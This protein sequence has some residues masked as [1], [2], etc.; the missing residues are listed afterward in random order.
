MESAKT[1]SMWMNVNKAFISAS[2]TVNN[3]APAF[4]TMTQSMKVWESEAI[5]G[6]NNVKMLSY[7]SQS[8]AIA[9]HEE[10]Q[11][12]TKPDGKENTIW[13]KLVPKASQGVQSALA[14]SDAMAQTANQI[15]F[16]NSGL[17]ETDN[18]QQKI[19]RSAQASRLSYQDTANAVANLGIQAKG[20]FSSS[21]EVVGFAELIGKQFQI[22]GASS[23]DTV[24]AMDQLSQTMSDGV[25]SG[26]ELNSIFGQ[27]P[28]IMQN[29]ADYMGKPIDKVM[30]MGENGQISADTLKNALFNA[31]DEIN[32]NFNSVPMTWE[33]IGTRIKNQALMA[34]QPILTKVNEIANSEKFQGFVNGIINSLFALANV[35]SPVFDSLSN[36]GSLIYDNWDIISPIIYAVAAALAFYTAIVAAHNIVEEISNTLK[37][38]AAVRSVAHGAAITS[39]MMATTGMTASQLSLNAALYACPLTWII[40]AIIALIAIIYAVVG[41]INHLTGSTLSATGVIMGALATVGAFIWNT[42]VGVINAVIQFM[43]TYFVEPFISIIEW[44]LNAFNG[45]FNSFGEAV[46]NLLGQIISW[47]LSLGK[48]VTKIIDAIFGTNWTDG[49]SSLQESVLSWGKNDEAITINRDAPAIDRINYSDAYNTGYNFGEGIDNKVSKFFDGNNPASNP[50]NDSFKDTFQGMNDSINNIDTNTASG[51]ESAGQ[52]ADSVEITD[53]DI[54]YLR[55]IAEREI[56]DRTVFKSLRVD[57]GGVNNT[58]NNMSDLNGIADYLGDVI[59]QTASASMEG[60]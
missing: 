55:D 54:Q 26:D 10:K 37:T 58:V 29:I 8:V 24:N 60:A 12:K 52:V 11:S 2:K 28:N 9:N 4:Q 22:A 17:G 44:I 7:Q 43:W 35:T 49:L 6:L 31:S 20:A 34:F 36:F 1:E 59:S 38:L 41:A 39:E 27:T 23:D 16:M 32:E 42:V 40:I 56:I 53:E 45:G 33:Q 13:S 5:N 30:E 57:M 14:L 19:F 25:M 46:A 3:M 50:E 47:F 18:I 15:N 51:A 21:D 48:V